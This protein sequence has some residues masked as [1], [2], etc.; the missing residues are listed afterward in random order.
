MIKSQIKKGTCLL[1]QREAN[2]IWER[3]DWDMGSK[4]TSFFS[5]LGL[6]MFFLPMIPFGTVLALLGCTIEYFI[7][8]YVIIRRSN[9]KISYSRTVCETFTKEYEFCL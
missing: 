7:D 6:S 3:Q 4:I 2:T 5:N 9:T 1:T 8:W